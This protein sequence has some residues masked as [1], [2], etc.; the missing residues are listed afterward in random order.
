MIVRLFNRTFFTKKADM[1]SRLVLSSVFLHVKSLT[2]DAEK[3]AYL[4]SVAPPPLGNKPLF[5]TLW[6]ALAGKAEWL[7]PKGAPKLDA[8]KTAKVAKGR[9]GSEPSD[10]L[11]E[12]RKLYLFL[13]GTGDHM[14]KIRREKLFRDML[15]DM[16][17][18]EGQ[19]LIAIKDGKFAET[20]GIT[21]ALL[22]EAFPGLLTHPGFGNRFIP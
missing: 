18:E 20:Y 19:L 13:K 8:A 3:V 12:L 5:Y 21:P 4:R 7:L 11:R 9:P 6:L 2:T 1:P 14:Q 15:E 16:S 17:P 10:V 22:D